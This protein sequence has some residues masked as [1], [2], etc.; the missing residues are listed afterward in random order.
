RLPCRGGGGGPAAV[1]RLSPQ[2]GRVAAATGHGG[3]YRLA[4]LGD[5]RRGLA[6]TRAAALALV[7]FRS[8][9]IC[10]SPSCCPR[11]TSLVASACL[12]PT[13][14]ACCAGATMSAPWPYSRVTPRCD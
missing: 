10:G 2:L 4:R 1:G 14:S 13:P 12:Q 7:S 3:C 11:R 5:A 8:E 9:G 6:Y